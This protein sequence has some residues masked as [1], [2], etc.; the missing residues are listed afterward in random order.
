VVKV[1]DFGLVKELDRHEAVSLTSETTITGTPLYMSP[2]A[3]TSPEKVDARSDL[4]A[5]G[6]LGY[7]LVTGQNVFDGGSVVEVCS[8]HLRSIPVSPSA[9]LGSP[10]PR[11]LEEV[12]LECLEKDPARRPKDAAALATALAICTDATDWTDERAVAWWAEREAT[13]GQPQ[14]APAAY[15]TTIAIDL[16]GRAAG[17]WARSKKAG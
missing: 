12:I 6:A 10:V 3:I 7:Y 4:Y 8:H 16:R 13:A 1:V 11:D 17:C 14:R 5:I 15:A 9:R 2:E